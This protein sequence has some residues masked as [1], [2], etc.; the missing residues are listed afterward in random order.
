MSCVVFDYLSVI[1]FQHSDVY[2]YVIMYFIYIYSN[3]N[4]STI[5]LADVK[6]HINPAVK[7]ILNLKIKSDKEKK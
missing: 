4:R 1:I 2:S 5:V 6:H 7:D 3:Y